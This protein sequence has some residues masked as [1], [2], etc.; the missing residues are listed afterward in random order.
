[1]GNDAALRAARVLT[2]MLPYGQHRETDE[3]GDVP[4]AGWRGADV[5]AAPGSVALQLRGMLGLSGERRSP[6]QDA[7]R[8]ARR[9][10][11]Q[12]VR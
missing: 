11:R 4:T 7:A 1:M 8:Q 12:A 6:P 2:P 10:M 3:P 5:P 9:A